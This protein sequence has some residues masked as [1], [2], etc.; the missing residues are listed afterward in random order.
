MAN[1]WKFQFSVSD[2]NGNP[3]TLCKRDKTV[4]DKAKK[5][6]KEVHQTECSSWNNIQSDKSA[7]IYW[8][9]KLAMR[10]ICILCYMFI[11]LF[12]HV[13]IHIGIWSLMAPLMER[14][15]KVIHHVHG[16]KWIDQ[17]TGRCW[18]SLPSSSYLHPR[19][20]NNNRHVPSCDQSCTLVLSVPSSRFTLV[21]APIFH[22][23]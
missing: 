5:V 6:S 15:G 1:L 17:L 22:G 21:T 4:W 12:Y 9:N 13:C 11:G 3:S 18:I 19:G 10:I 7:I 16:F 23:P 2:F 8:L 14:V 20:I